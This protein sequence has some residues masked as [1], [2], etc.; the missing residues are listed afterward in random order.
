MIFIK[1][2]KYKIQIK[3][4][5]MEKGGKGKSGR[6]KSEGKGKKKQLFPPSKLHSR[7]IISIFY[8][9]KNSKY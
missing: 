9:Y 1:L 5:K 2:L 8:L 3:I 7:S 4:K 6:E